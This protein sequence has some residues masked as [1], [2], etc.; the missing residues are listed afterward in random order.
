MCRRLDYVLCGDWCWHC[1][2]G[3]R[4]C[5]LRVYSWCFPVEDVRQ[6]LSL[7]LRGSLVGSNSID[8]PV[9]CS[10]HYKL[11][12]DPWVVQPAG[13]CRTKWIVCL[14]AWNAC[15]TTH[16]G[17]CFDEG[18]VAGVSWST[19]KM[20]MVFVQAAEEHQGGRVT[21]TSW[22]GAQASLRYLE[23]GMMFHNLWCC[24]APL[25]SPRPIFWRFFC[26]KQIWSLIWSVHHLYLTWFVAKLAVLLTTAEG[27]TQPIVENHC[28]QQTL[29]CFIS[30]N[31]LHPQ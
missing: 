16:S 8:A 31:S 11:F 24:I 4:E 19:S 14:I 12:I 30:K 21:S 17:N 6:S 13:W 22:R 26:V 2:G 27:K 29:G 20:E 25:Q 7:F 5:G 15:R 23:V 18:V 10:F 9:A 28:I 3:E 1:W